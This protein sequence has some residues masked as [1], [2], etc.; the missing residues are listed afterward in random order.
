MANHAYIKTDEVVDFERL[1]ELLNEVNEERFNGLLKFT[2]DE[3]ENYIIALA[4]EYNSFIEIWIPTDRD[5]T[6]EIRHGHAL[7]ASWYTD[8]FITH[9]IAEKVNGTVTDDSDGI[10]QTPYFHTKHPKMKTY[11]EL[12][13][14]RKSTPKNIQKLLDKMLH[15]ERDIVGDELWEVLG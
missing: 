5:H 11:V 10:A 14:D 2:I 12:F 15:N 4:D 1:K 8:L 7:K 3:G 13:Y 6:L 9:W